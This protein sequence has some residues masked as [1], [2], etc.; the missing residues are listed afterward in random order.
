MDKQYLIGDCYIDLSRNQIKRFEQIETLQPK[1]LSVL[2]ILAKNAG[3]VVSHDT[4][5]DEVWA[6]AT[7][8]PNTLQR[9]IAQLRKALGDDS[10]SQHIIKTHSKKGYS[11][12]VDVEWLTS[13]ADTPDTF[14][15]SQWPFPVFAII[16]LLIFLASWLYP[17]DKLS[18]LNMTVVTASDEREFYPN[19]SPDGKYLVFHRYM[20]TCKN[21]IW[22]KNLQ[23]QQ[24]IQL[25]KT[26][27]I[28]GPHSWSTDGNQIAFTLQENCAKLPSENKVCWQL[29]TLDFA[30]A[31]QTPQETTLRLDCD[32]QW[33]GR[34]RWIQDGSITML[35]DFDGVIKLMRYNLRDDTQK[36]FYESSVGNI[37][38]FDYAPKQDIFAVVSRTP[39]EKQ[40]LEIID[41]TGFTISSAYIQKNDQLSFYQ[42]Y[43]PSFHPDENQLLVNTDRGLYQLSFDGKLTAIETPNIENIYAPAFHPSENKL[44]ASHGKIDTD[45]AMVQLAEVDAEQ[46]PVKFNEVYQPYPSIDRSTAFEGNGQFQPN[47]DL[48]AYISQRTGTRQLK[49]FD[50]QESRQ[51]SRFSKGSRVSA[52]NWSP[53]GQ[54]IAIVVDDRINLIGLDGETRQVES[55]I[56]IANLSQWVDKDRLMVTGNLNKNDQFLLFDLTDNSFTETGLDNIRWA[57]YTASGE[58]IYA[59][60]D[61]N[62]WR[63]A[64]SDILQLP[65]TPAQ[66]D[67]KAFVLHRIYLYG[68]NMNN[69]LW[70]LDL[71]TN[72][73]ELIKK[74]SDQVWWLSDVNDDSILVT[75]GIAAKKE[76][77][78]I[79]P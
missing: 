15:K 66:V 7:V 37:Y 58:L 14:K 69:E 27:A 72:E 63:K 26:A 31:I 42:D 62:M 41:H 34:P 55:S 44:T 5:M 39:D 75:Q 19:Y 78:E 1:V 59:D 73:L 40:L 68:L 12:E 21:H 36:V 79:T 52:F 10:K 9:C 6:E 13:D 32:E 67:G 57:R 48:I 49:L 35:K 11:I 74:L 65:L 28:Y 33:I 56:P 8:N 70:R 25:T 23:N 46:N 77:V 53:D 17:E 29:Q 71:T 45:L 76:V 2:T 4:L 64:G 18:Y 24:E 38:S 30:A 51:L 3:Q 50:G 22:A 47:G 20:G 61:H 16:V 43:S 54:T 60:N